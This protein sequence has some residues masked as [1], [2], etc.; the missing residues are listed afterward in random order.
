MNW[1]KSIRKALLIT[2]TFMVI[3]G[4]IYPL[5]LTGIGQIVFPKQANG[6]LVKEDGKVIG[7]ALIG[8]QFEG[9]GH[10]ISR[11]SAVSYNMYE[12]GDLEFEGVSS[13][14]NNYAPSNPALIERM[15][16]SIEQFI[17]NNPTIKKEE[18]PAELMTSSGS[19][20]DPHISVK[21][22]EVQIPRIVKETGLS[23]EQVESIIKK[24]IEHK[25]F[26]IFGEE[27]MNVLEANQLIEKNL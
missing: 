24:S 6:S 17:L 16:Q 14:S 23:N 11:P 26:N 13:G 15:D 20:L 12:K 18:I 2:V 3:C 22:A 9:K 19:G 4:L 21:S 27:K 7:S 10:F 25:V 1:F 8:Q 5:L